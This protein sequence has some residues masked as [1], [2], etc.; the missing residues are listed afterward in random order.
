MTLEMVI[1]SLPELP[2]GW[3]YN[4]YQIMLTLE[5]HLLIR[6]TSSMDR[7]RPGDKVS[8]VRP[9]LCSDCIVTASLTSIVEMGIGSLFKPSVHRTANVDHRM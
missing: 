5:R 9:T 4:R 6:I 8:D 2:M 3:A 1:R 7:V